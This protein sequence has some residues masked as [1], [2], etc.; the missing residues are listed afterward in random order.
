MNDQKA[1]RAD[2]VNLSM[3]LAQHSFGTLWRGS[4]GTIDFASSFLR[5]AP[6]GVFHPAAGGSPSAVRRSRSD[7]PRGK[8]QT[9][10]ILTILWTEI[11][12]ILSVRR[13]KMPDGLRRACGSSE[14]KTLRKIFPLAHNRLIKT[15]PETRGKG[16]RTEMTLAVM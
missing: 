10:G 16:N 12:V 11:E 15:E 2:D 3:I 7:S 8:E 14:S 5:A 9:L 6:F 4:H 13:T 1:K